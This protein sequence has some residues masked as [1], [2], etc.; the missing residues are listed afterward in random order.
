MR[1]EEEKIVNI[2][3]LKI[4]YARNKI[5]KCNEPLY[6][7]D[8]KNRLVYCRIC[9]AIIDPFEAIYKLALNMEFINNEIHRA[10]EYKK[11]ID[12]YKPYLR[13]AKRYEKMMREKEM[14][15][16]CPH[17]TKPFKWNEIVSMTNK[18]FYKEI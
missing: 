6:E 16:V 8:Y 14:L 13:E 4:N 15:P 10:I 17:C 7:I 5:C 2:E 18:K 9:Q 11:E 3:T 12:N 1:N